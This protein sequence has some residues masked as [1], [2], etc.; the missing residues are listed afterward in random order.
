MGRIIGVGERLRFFDFLKFVKDRVN[1]E[2]NEFK[3]D[4][5]VSFLK[6]RRGSEDMRVKFL[7]RVIFLVIKFKFDFSKR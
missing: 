6:E 1:F 2:N 3:E 4:F 5:V 7:L